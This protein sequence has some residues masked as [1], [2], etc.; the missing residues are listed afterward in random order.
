MGQKVRLLFLCFAVSLAVGF[1]SGRRYLSSP[2]SPGYT[3]PV[4][5]PELPLPLETLQNPMF[6]H[7]SGRVKGVIITKNDSFFTV[8]TNKTDK[9]ALTVQYVAGKTQF[10]QKIGT[11]VKEVRYGDVA[12]NTAVSGVVTIGTLNNSWYVVGDTFSLF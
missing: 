1:F 4:T 11:T 5:M 10:K 8:A 7:W 3:L 9:A 6:S 12:I 2:P